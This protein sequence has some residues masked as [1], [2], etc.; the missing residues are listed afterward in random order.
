MRFAIVWLWLITAAPLGALAQQAQAAPQ[1]MTVERLALILT[2]VAEDVRREGNVFDVLL[3][4]RRLQVITDPAADRMRILVAITPAADLS[5]ALLERL[6]QANFDTAL[7]AR[8]AIARGIVWSTFIHPLSP[9][10]DD[11]L[12][13]GLAQTLIAAETYGSTF[14]SGALSFGGGDS[15]DLLQDLKKRWESL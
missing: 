12:F 4:G 9:L 3:E 8:Y 1:G 11:Q 6:L 14:T 7:D 2:S 13:S 15:V 10:T 5:A